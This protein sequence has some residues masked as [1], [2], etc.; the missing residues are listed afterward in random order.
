LYG[1]FAKGE[2]GPDSDLDLLIITS[3]SVEPS[4]LRGTPWEVNPTFMSLDE[5][6]QTSKSNQPFHNDILRQGIVLHG[7]LPVIE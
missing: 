6:V 7:T 4:S 1:S 2:N 5:W 3:S